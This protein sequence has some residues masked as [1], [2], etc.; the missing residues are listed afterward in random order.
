MS[1]LERYEVYLERAAEQDLKRLSV[2]NFQRIITN[3]KALSQN[4]RPAG[5]RKLFGS[6]NDWHIRVGSYRIIIDDEEKAVRVMRL[7][8]RRE[9]YKP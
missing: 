3:I 1:T 7:R 5:C 4:P 9:A 2:K 8:H 6:K